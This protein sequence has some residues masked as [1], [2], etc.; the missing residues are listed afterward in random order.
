MIESMA[1]NKR[2]RI[3]KDACERYDPEPSEDER[4]NIESW[5]AIN[6]KIELG[7]T[8]G[9]NNAIIKCFDDNT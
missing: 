1:E 9:Y 5:H 2:M 3:E 6:L 8:S 7:D 4:M